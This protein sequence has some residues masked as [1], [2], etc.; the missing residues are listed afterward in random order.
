MASRNLREAIAKERLWAADV[1]TIAGI[2]RDVASA[3]M[4]LHDRGIVHGDI[5]VKNVVRGR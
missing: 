2:A 1:G 3:I 5:H 4:Y